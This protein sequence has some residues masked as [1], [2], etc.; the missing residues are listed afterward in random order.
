MSMMSNCCSA[1]RWGETDICSKCKEHADFYEEDVL[2]KG[3]LIVGQDYKVVSGLMIA[4][5]DGDAITTF[6][7][8]YILTFTGQTDNF[9][10]F[11]TKDKIKIEL[12]D[13]SSSM[14]EC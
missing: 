13:I 10:Y 6:P 2:Q 14:M 8:G 11:E 1:P 7:V 12:W 4:G 3:D 9:F 5:H